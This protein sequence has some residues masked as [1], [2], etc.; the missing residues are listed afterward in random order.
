MKYALVLAA[1]PALLGNLLLM[2]AIGIGRSGLL[3]QAFVSGIALVVCTL[4]IKHSR[5]TLSDR[6]GTWIG[7]SSAAFLALPLLLSSTDNPERW[8]QIAGSKL[9][10]SG[11]VTPTTVAVLAFSNRLA[12]ETKT[13]IFT[14]HIAV[15]IVLAIEPDAPQLTAYFPATAI[16][17]FEGKGARNV[18]A[19]TILSML[20]A[21]LWA[22]TQP[23]PL[24]PVSHVEGVLDVAWS[25]G[26]LPAA[27]AIISLALPIAGFAYVG[28]STR[29][30]ALL[31]VAIYYAVICMLAG[32]T[33]MTPMPLLG[34]G[35]GP[36]VGYFAVVYVAYRMHTS[37][38]AVQPVGE[39]RI[40]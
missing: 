13:W 5:K 3:A 20:G 1:V 6:A 40:R 31:A 14:C 7:I 39:A 11:L 32:I 17:V 25:F 15:A 16:P 9:Y 2:H 37:K 22:W 18:K 28:A 8:V 24:T 19:L 34:A 36:V 26:A 12:A 35:T 29:N 10:I 38:L 27:A 4:A 33:Q 30:R 23:D 21:T